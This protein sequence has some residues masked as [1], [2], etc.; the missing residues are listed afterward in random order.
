MILDGLLYFYW[1]FK[2]PMM[3]SLWDDIKKQIYYYEEKTGAVE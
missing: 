3:T 1:Y 2:F